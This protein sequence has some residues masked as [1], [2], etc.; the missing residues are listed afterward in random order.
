[1]NLQI[2]FRD[3]PPSPALEARIERKMRGLERLAGGVITCR[4]VVERRHHHHHQGNLYH[5]G[6]D[7]SVPGG[8]IVISKDHD[9][10]R[11]HEDPY[12]ALRDAVGAARRQL[13]DWRRR[14][15]A[16]VKQH[17]IPAHGRVQQVFPNLDYGVIVMPDQREIYFHR[18][19]ALDGFE[20]L[21]IGSEVRFELHEAAGE[22]G[23][24]A[25]SVRRVGKHHVPSPAPH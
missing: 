13:Q 1:M 23:P 9:L 25:S 17:D 5:V 18:N 20:A 21:E 12:I 14:V 8:E 15:R 2:S 19:A 16:A 6:I 10:D 11:T 22:E 7:L 4:V 24:H 3:M